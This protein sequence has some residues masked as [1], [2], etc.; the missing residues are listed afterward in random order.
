M[1][2]R[3]LCCEIAVIGLANEQSPAFLCSFSFAVCWFLFVV[4]WLGDGILIWPRRKILICLLLTRCH[5]HVLNRSFSRPN[6]LLMCWTLHMF[7]QGGLPPPLDP[8]HPSLLCS[9]KTLHAPSHIRTAVRPPADPQS[10]ADGY[11]AR[12]ICW[13]L[14]NLEL[15]KFF[16][17]NLVDTVPYTAGLMTAALLLVQ[18]LACPTAAAVSWLDSAFFCA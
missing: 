17:R 2:D 18:G 10:D 9:S 4:C 12:G 1:Q 14:S 7:R 15:C 11:W 5:F 6:N 16:S 8:V 3:K 13:G